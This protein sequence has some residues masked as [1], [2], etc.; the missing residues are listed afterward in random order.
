M[1]RYSLVKRILNEIPFFFVV[2]IH[3]FNEE[4]CFTQITLFAP[5]IKEVKMLKRKRVYVISLFFCLD[6]DGWDNSDNNFDWMKS[7]NL[8]QY[9]IFEIFW[10]LRRIERRHSYICWFVIH[11]MVWI[12]N[13]DV[14]SHYSSTRKTKC[15][16][17]KKQQTNTDECKQI[18]RRCVKNPY[19][20]FVKEILLNTK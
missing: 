18:Q 16:S 9:S 17:K 13:E 4:S 14:S 10:L 19:I 6:F 5:K 20:R 1:E 7:G 3:Y 8:K 2:N 15:K 11:W 12:Q